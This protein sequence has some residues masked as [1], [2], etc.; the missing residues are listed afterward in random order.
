MYLNA[1]YERENPEFTTKC[2]HHY[3]LSCILEW[4]ERSDACPIC[5]Q[6]CHLQQVIYAVFLCEC[7]IIV[8]YHECIFL[9][10]FRVHLHS[11]PVLERKLFYQKNRRKKEVEKTV[12]V[13]A[14]PLYFGGMTVERS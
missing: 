13:N 6:V 2:G 8:L 9:D 4:M 1:E 14:A 11:S 10:V 12:K 7:I 5:D 3:H